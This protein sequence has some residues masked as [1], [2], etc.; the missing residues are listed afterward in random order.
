VDAQRLKDNFAQVAQHGD[1]VALFFYSD[2]FL[3]HPEVRD[4]FPV[5][6]SHQRDRL[7][8]AL[9]RIVS[10]VD[11]LEE[12]GPFAQQLGRDHRKF[13]VIAEHFPAV[14]QS[15]IATLRYFSG[16]DWTP[17]LEAD[18]AAAYQLLAQVMIDSAAAD[19]EEHPP[20]WVATVVEHERRTFDV[21]AFRV[22]TDRPLAYLPGQAVSV[23]YGRRPKLWRYYSM[24]NAPRRDGTID[25]HVRIVDGGP[26]SPVMVRTLAVGEQ[27][28]L[29]PPIGQMTLDTESPRDIL[30]IG[31]STGLAPLKAILE[32]IATQSAP[33][34]V[35]LFF[36]ARTTDGLYDLP[37]LEKM[38]ASFPWL[39]LVT[40]VSHDDGYPG[41]RGRLPDVV[42]RHGPWDR[43][44]AY[45][46]GPPAMVD[47]TTR[48]LLQVGVPPEQIRID[49][50]V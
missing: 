22:T 40:A 36:G 34:K 21:A 5:A 12:L 39:T 17:E 48:R 26:V 27:L 30:L 1:G 23:Q 25:F 13:G 20:W 8:T 35:H 49:E 29:G 50:F 45:V 6:M 4:Y 41:E 3:R 9:G 16:P 46:C 19:A 47:A 24:A 18:W 44:D 31:G 7:L 28:R 14:G 37:D 43:R 32:H 15:L 42:A 2:L 11:R 33:P 10:Q 38:A